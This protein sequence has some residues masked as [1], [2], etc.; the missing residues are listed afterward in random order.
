MSL[1]KGKVLVVEE[2]V[3]SAH[4]LFS[5]LLSLGYDVIEPAINYTE[6]VKKTEQESPDLAILDIQL[7]RNKTGIDITKNQC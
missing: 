5:S 3:L 4:K 1:G 2:E 7:S 6:A